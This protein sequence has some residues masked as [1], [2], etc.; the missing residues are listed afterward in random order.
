M[1]KRTCRRTTARSDLIVDTSVV[2]VDEAGYGCL[3]GP[4]SVCALALAPGADQESVRQVRDSKK[5]P[6]FGHKRLADV[7]RSVAACYAV[8]FI[9]P[10][11]ID[12][13]GKKSKSSLLS[14]K[15]RGIHFAIDC[16]VG[17]C[18]ADDAPAHIELV[19]CAPAREPNA[20][21]SIIMDGNY[22]DPPHRLLPHTCIEKA[23]NSHACVAAA[24]LIAKSVRDLYMKD[25]CLKYP[26]LCEYGMDANV[27]YW[28]HD[29]AVAIQVK[30]YTRIHR[31]SFKTCTGARARTDAG[32][33]NG[34][35]ND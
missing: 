23:D 17:H 35:K 1:R 20:V 2:G 25:L 19:E 12:V 29:H 5:I 4:V 15:M 24:S 6:T 3:A 28:R 33:M 13:P 30:G 14:S 32:D 9:H 11:A 10:E 31:R 21:S 8:V 26:V 22:F 34:I 18:T 27:G 16:M 7:A